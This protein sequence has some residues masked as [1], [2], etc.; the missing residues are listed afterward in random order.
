VKFCALVL[1]FLSIAPASQSQSPDPGQALIKRKCR[2]TRI[3]LPL[4][5]NERNFPALF[6]TIEVLDYRSDTSRIGLMTNWE[7][8]QQEVLFRASVT[9]VLTA[10]LNYNY[11][12]PKGKN[13]LLVV[14]KD[15][16]LSTA[17]EKDTTE[18]VGRKDMISRRQL[19][20]VSFRFEAYWRNEEG[21]IPL[22]YL[23]TL[24]ISSRPALLFMV[25]RK[26]PELISLF[27]AKVAAVDMST[28]AMKRR[29]VSYNGIDSFCRAR[30]NYPMDTATKLLKGAYA[31]VDEFR[32]NNPSITDYELTKDKASNLELRIRDT[33]G[34]LYYTHTMWG[35]CD[36]NQCYVMMDGNLFPVFCIH[37]QFYVL[38]S[39]EYRTKS[40]PL[41]F[42]VPVTSA[43]FLYGIATVDQSVLRKLSLFRLNVQSGEVIY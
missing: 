4:D 38:G 13:S 3:S 24:A 15:L 2:T 7:E 6:N 43:A 23:D 17:I 20:N 34:K 33:D 16:W 18:G 32:N 31:N 10:Y 14:V 21:Y 30:F 25:D 12:N 37:H 42:F 39:K 22:T 28:I 40:I 19:G 29:V 9:N 8:S 26:L 5:Q 27:M 36:G 11:S 35:F 1:L 41:L